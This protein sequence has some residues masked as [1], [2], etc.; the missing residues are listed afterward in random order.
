MLLSKKVKV[1]NGGKRTFVNKL[2]RGEQWG[3][4]WFKGHITTH[5]QKCQD[6]TCSFVGNVKN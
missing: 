1:T 3:G 2:M 6:K 4:Q 5:V